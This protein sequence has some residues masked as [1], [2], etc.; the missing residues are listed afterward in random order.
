MYDTGRALHAAFS[1]DRMYFID[2]PKLRVGETV[3]ET[4][5]IREQCDDEPLTLVMSAQP[6]GSI[7]AGDF[8]RDV[9]LELILDGVIV[10]DGILCCND[11]RPDTAN[12]P[13]SIEIYST[14]DEH[15][16]DIRV[17]AGGG[18]KKGLESIQNGYK[19]SK[20][21]RDI[22]SICGVL[23]DASRAHGNR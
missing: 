20:K 1:V 16:L 23:I 3:T 12:E 13:V 2:L 14:D 8:P 5:T 4:L 15:R 19:H 10:Y 6:E 9:G 17:T 11:H 22:F 21:G 7:A 18:S